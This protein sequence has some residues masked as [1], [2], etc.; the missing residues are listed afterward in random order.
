MADSLSSKGVKAFPSQG[1]L[2]LS[3]KSYHENWRKCV[4][5]LDDAGRS[6]QRAEIGDVRNRGANNEATFVLEGD[7]SQQV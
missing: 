4:C 6:D 2:S 1:R 5:E 3:Y 7:F